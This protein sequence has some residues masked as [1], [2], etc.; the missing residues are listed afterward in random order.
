MSLSADGQVQKSYHKGSGHFQL[1]E[2][3]L[4]GSVLLKAG[5]L[6]SVQFFI[7]F[8]FAKHLL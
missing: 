6:P 5:E 2:L 3:K 7:N 1:S 4:A 8:S